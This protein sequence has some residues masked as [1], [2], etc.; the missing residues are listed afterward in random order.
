MS[1]SNR[2]KIAIIAYAFAFFMTGCGGGGGG[3]SG[4]GGGGGGGGGAGYNGFTPNSLA[5]RR[6]LGTRTFTSTGP[7]GQTHT[8]TFS[9]T[10]FHDSDPPEEA[11]G[12]YVYNPGNNTAVLDLDYTS[13]AGFANDSHNLTM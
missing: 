12:N 9:A 8:Y 7:V 13:P 6:M 2:F 11:D 10:R 5:G 4:G 1:T 3:S